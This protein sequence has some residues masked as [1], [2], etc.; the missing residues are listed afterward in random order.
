MRRLTDHPLRRADGGHGLGHPLAGHIGGAGRAWAKVLGH[1]EAVK[2]T[3]NGR[4]DLTYT[5]PVHSGPRAF[6]E[7]GVT[8]AGIDY[9]SVDDSFTVTVLETLEDL[10]FCAKGGAAR[11]CPMGRS[12]R[13]TDGCRSLPTAGDSATTIRPIAA[14]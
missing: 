6:G 12:S 8:P 3:G 5:G 13:R 4:I 10:G 2:R 11:S 9:A 14:A 7:A 1:G